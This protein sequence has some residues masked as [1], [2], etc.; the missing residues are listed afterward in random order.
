ME[1]LSQLSIQDGYTY[2]SLPDDRAIR[3]IQLLIDPRQPHGFSL[4]SCTVSL[5]D[6]PLYCALSYTWKSATISGLARHAED[7]KPPALVT[8]QCDGKDLVITENA[9]DFLCRA[10]RERLFIAEND[11]QELLP[12]MFRLSEYQTTAQNGVFPQ[13]VWIDAISINQR[14]VEERSHQVSFMGDI[15]QQS[16]TTIVWLGKEEPH[17]EAKWVIQAFMPRFLTLYR[18]RGRH[19]FMSKDPACTDPAVTEYF[20]EEICS[21]WRSSFKFFFV[22]LIQRRWFLRGWV[23][24]EVILRTFRECG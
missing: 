21:R 23:V 9:F 12:E 10:F 13:Y 11:D 22:F 4:T 6:T 15:F 24:Q 1:S 5:R 2:E 19:Y 18:E 16:L 3:L 7:D 14:D 20:G 17:P 8:V